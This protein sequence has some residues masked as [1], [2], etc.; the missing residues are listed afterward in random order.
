MITSKQIKAL[1]E[2]AK[3]SIDKFA[4]A[5][6][7]SPTTV[8]KFEQGNQISKISLQKIEKVFK[9]LANKINGSD[10]LIEVKKEDKKP[11]K[12]RAHGVRAVIEY[13]V[14]AEAILDVNE[15]VVDKNN[16]LVTR[17][18]YSNPQSPQVVDSGLNSR[19]FNIIKIL[20]EATNVEPQPF[21]SK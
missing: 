3:L 15:E 4:K 7:L 10:S 14:R 17:R 6:K 21:Y 9:Q 20:S 1:R 18:T 13:I 11:D 16:P 8:L 2:K 12:V 19:N 5:A